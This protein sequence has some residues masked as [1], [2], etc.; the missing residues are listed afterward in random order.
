MIW[1]ASCCGESELLR[2]PELLHVIRA[3]KSLMS[4]DGTEAMGNVDSNGVDYLQH[5]KAA[6][7][8]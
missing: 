5:A 4:R 3:N 2:F 8:L 1:G 7:H 6:L